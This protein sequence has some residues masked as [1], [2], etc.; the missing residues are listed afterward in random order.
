MALIARQVAFSCRP[1]K[2]DCCDVFRVSRCFLRRDLWLISFAYQTS[3]KRLSSQDFST[4]T[5][6]YNI[7][8]VFAYKLCP[9][10]NRT[11]WPR[12]AKVKYSDMSNEMKTEVVDII[13]GSGRGWGKSMSSEQKGK[14]GGGW[15]GSS[16]FEGRDLKTCSEKETHMSYLHGLFVFCIV[17]F[18]FL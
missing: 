16:V 11:T 7:Y 15:I 13:A 12:S 10:S 3:K 9:L 4:N 17:S 1:L 8:T 2:Q 5:Y 14:V 18:L 6:K